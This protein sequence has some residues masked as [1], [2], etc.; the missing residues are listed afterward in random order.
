MVPRV[1]PK[2]EDRMITQTYVANLKNIP[3]NYIRVRVARP[4]VLSPSAD[5]LHEYK[6][7]EAE[8]KRQL[9][10]IEARWAAVKHTNFVERFTQEITSNDKA[11]ARLR[12]LANLSAQSKTIVLFCYEKEPPCH[13]FILLDLL[14]MYFNAH[15]VTGLESTHTKVEP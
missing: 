1:W 4:S 12:E 3:T 13:R 14:R 2:K 10:P 15:V 6:N 7:S 11:M 8:Y 9:T 5:L